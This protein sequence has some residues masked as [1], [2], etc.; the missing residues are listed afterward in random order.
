MYSDDTVV[1]H[2]VPI[3]T[4]YQIVNFG[5]KLS[6]LTRDLERFYLLIDLT[7]AQRP[8]AEIINAV[9]KAMQERP[10]MAHVGVYTGMNFMLNIAAKFVLERVGFV[11]YSLHKTREDALQAIQDAKEKS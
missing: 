1:W 8:S 2:E 7:E 6:E 9:R 4:T 5:Q 3:Q 10:G 11:S